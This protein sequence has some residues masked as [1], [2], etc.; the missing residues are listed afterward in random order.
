MDFV[1]LFFF[2]LCTKSVLAFNHSLSHSVKKTFFF[3]LS[4]IYKYFH[5]CHF[6][7]VLLQCIR[8]W[9]WSTCTSYVQTR[10]FFHKVVCTYERQKDV[11]KSRNKMK[12]FKGETDVRSTIF[13][14]TARISNPDT[15]KNYE[16]ATCTSSIIYEKISVEDIKK[17]DMETLKRHTGNLRERKFVLQIYQG[18]WSKYFSIVC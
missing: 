4:V 15:E 14:C 6:P 13:V 2:S 8:P 12:L 11:W 17:E 7:S 3:A 5:F 1:N 18:E 10:I 16:H 9:Y